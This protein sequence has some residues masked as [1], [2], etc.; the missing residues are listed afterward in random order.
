MS[1][2]TRNS[3]H[4]TRILLRCALNRYATKQLYPSFRQERTDFAGRFIPVSF[5]G[6]KEPL[7]VNKNST[8]DSL[9]SE[10]E[11]EDPKPKLSVD[12]SVSPTIISTVTTRTAST[13]D[14]DERKD[15]ANS[16]RTMKYT[17]TI[18]GV[19]GMSGKTTRIRGGR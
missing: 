8:N 2:L 4:L 6:T 16:W 12:P 18:F 14:E 17:F 10:D 13:A 3:L 19:T 15:D 9:E 7:N 5:Y 11:T 1:I